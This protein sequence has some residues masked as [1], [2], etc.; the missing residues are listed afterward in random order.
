MAN[1]RVALAIGWGVCGSGAFAQEPYLYVK[2]GIQ[3]LMLYRPVNLSIDHKVDKPVGVSYVRAV[4]EMLDGKKCTRWVVQHTIWPHAGGP[5]AQVDFETST[6]VSEDG[7]VQR[8]FATHQKYTTL[9]SV[10]ARRVD[11]ELMRLDTWPGNGPK[12]TKMLKTA[13]GNAVFDRAFQGLLRS[14]DAK[15]EDRI[16]FATLDPIKG[17]PVTQTA[18]VKNRV[19]GR[20]GDQ[21]VEGRSIE[22]TSPTGTIVAYV[23]NGGVLLQ[24]DFEKGVRLLPLSYVPEVKYA[25]P[26]GIPRNPPPF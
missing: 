3:T 13:G 5:D 7:K 15:P 26:P 11:E 4:E 19:R 1:L 8:I 23:S 6:W 2:G 18:R 24:V 21:D 17:V 25:P 22:V 20:F 16:T 10:D 14:K 12:T 9:H